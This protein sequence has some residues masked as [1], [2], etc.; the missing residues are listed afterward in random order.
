MDFLAPDGHPPGLP[1]PEIPTDY[2]SATHRHQNSREWIVGPVRRG[3]FP[4]RPT[5]VSPAMPRTPTPI[6]DHAKSR[7]PLH[8]EGHR[9]GNQWATHGAIRFAASGAANPSTI[10]PIGTRRVGPV[11]KHET[12]PEYES[13]HYPHNQD[14]DDAP[15]LYRGSIRPGTGSGRDT[16]DL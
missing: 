2:H 10:M 6:Q 15:H 14:G 11:E 5:G 1:S 12:A 13:E 16:S 4:G 7:R 9:S 3:F 8:S